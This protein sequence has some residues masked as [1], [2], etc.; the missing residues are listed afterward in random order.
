MSS[1]GQKN[2][3]SLTRHLDT[4]DFE[5][6]FNALL[7][8]STQKHHQIPYDGRRLSQL[9]NGMQ[10]K[11]ISNQP[12]GK[13]NGC[14]SVCVCKRNVNLRVENGF[15][16]CFRYYRIGLANAYVLHVNLECAQCLS[17]SL[18]PSPSGAVAIS[19]FT[20]RW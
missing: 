3:K 14:W 9:C 17:H 10:M 4:S 16:C 18:T 1:C 12:M 15:R 13:S 6:I 8:L 5:D 2:T 20:F 19:T 7:L 11:C